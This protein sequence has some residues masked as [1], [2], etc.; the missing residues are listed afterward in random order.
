MSIVRHTSYNVVGALIPVAI[1]LITIPLYVQAIGLDRYGVLALCWLLVG[2]F[3]FF[4]FGLGQA[5]TQ[6]IAAHSSSKAA[7][8]SRIFWSGFGLAFGLAVI[9]ALVFVPISRLVL[10]IVSGEHWPLRQETLAALPLL[11]FAVPMG[12]LQSFL[13]GAL[14]GRQEF[15]KV[16]VLVTAGAVLTTVAPLLTAYYV[17][18][19]LE[20]LIKAS[21]ATRFALLIGLLLASIRAIPLHFPGEPNVRE[22]SRLLGFGAWAMVSNIVGPILTVF[23]RFVIGALAGAAA[24]GLYVI[25][26]NL[27]SQ[28]IVLPAALARALYPKVAAMDERQSKEMSE[29]ALRLLSSILTPTTLAL[30]LLLGPFLELWLGKE[31]GSAAAPIAYLLLFGLWANSLARIA[32][33]RLHALGRPKYGAIAHIAELLPYGVIL[34][35]AL[36][37]WGVVGAAVAWSARAFVDAIILG[38]GNRFDTRL[39]LSLTKQAIPILASI[40]LSLWL[41]SFSI[42][43]WLIVGALMIGTSLLLLRESQPELTAMVRRFRAGSFKL[44]EPG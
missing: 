30:A 32:M 29:T 22:L 18:N 2:Y 5:A 7:V 31:I 37:A 15:F 27:V 6:Q 38:A 26:F 35:F 41:P 10:P 12:I 1:S 33:A 19:S 21:L 8:R 43:R 17:G 16:N 39:M 44:N 36:K 28:V 24:V 25:P 3:A 23:D 11:L 4:D 9:A 13:T 34:Y 20:L 40:A 14:E 42:G